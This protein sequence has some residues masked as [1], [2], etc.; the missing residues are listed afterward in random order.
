M[1]FKTKV[2]I[3]NI[4]LL[5]IAISTVGFFM[6]KKNFELALDSQIRQAID[7]NNL[8]QSTLEYD[9]LDVTNSNTII[10]IEANMVTALTNS[11]NSIPK[12]QTIIY[13]VYNGSLI[14]TNSDG[15]NYPENLWTQTE[16]GKKVY[17]IEKYDDSYHIFT[18]SCNQ[19]FDKHLNIMT[20]K[21]ISSVYNLMEQQK[22][23]FRILLVIVLIFCS[24]FMLIISHMLTRPLMKL[25]EAS[26]NFGKGNYDERVDIHTSDEIGI[27]AHTYNK[28][29]TAVSNH[30]D[31]LQDM[32]TRREQFVADFTHEMKTPMTSIIGYADTIRSRELPRET[33][34]MA[35]SYIFT[36]GKRLED[37]SMKLFDLIYTG[38]NVLN[39]TPTNTLK[40]MSEVKSSILPGLDAK[41]V[42]L[43]FHSE[44]VLINAEPE[45]LKSALINIID[46]ARKASSKNSKII[47]KGEARKDKYLITIT[48]FGIGI[49]EDHINRIC[50][51]F[52]MVDKSRSRKEGGAGLGL[53]LA[54]L[55][56]KK[57]Y[58]TLDITSKLGEGTTMSIEF[59]IFYPENK[60][61]EH[62]EKKANN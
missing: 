23:Y 28:M 41:S 53:S 39:L 10:N 54:S 22:D 9:L 2:L 8:I 37:M 56:I 49:S 50:D 34:I 51:E 40:L 31:E 4:I 25:K 7:E 55:I 30:M 38:S 15:T 17:S 18:S 36:E 16:V 57:H 21:D 20:E 29:A 60:E 35:A 58:A 14:F 5:S 27:L 52:Y 3:T 47:F 46:N 43:D 24:L 13:V 61:D 45:L 42:S 59:D 62:E 11:L 44:N 6:I 26:E 12:N 1:K 33:Q 19:V 32:V 48:D